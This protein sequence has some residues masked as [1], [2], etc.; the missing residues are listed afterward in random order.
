MSSF[1][2]VVASQKRHVSGEISVSYTH[3]KRLPIFYD[4]IMG[5]SNHFMTH[6]SPFSVL[7][8]FKKSISIKHVSVIMAVSYTHLD[9]YKRQGYSNTEKVTL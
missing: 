4:V 3:L 5:E 2:P 9:V 6:A 7:R 1:S 8:V